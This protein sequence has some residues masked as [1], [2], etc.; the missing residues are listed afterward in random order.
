MTFYGLFF[1]SKNRSQTA[2]RHFTDDS[3]GKALRKI[4]QKVP[5]FELNK[6]ILNPLNK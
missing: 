5:I 3:T 1:V 6:I 2:I 4:G